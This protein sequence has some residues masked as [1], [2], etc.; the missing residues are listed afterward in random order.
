L[1][2]ACACAHCSRC[3]VCASTCA[4]TGAAAAADRTHGRACRPCACGPCLLKSLRRELAR[5]VRVLA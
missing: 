2:A 1:A 4:E 5:R 3:A